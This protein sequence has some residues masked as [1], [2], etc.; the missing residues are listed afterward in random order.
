MGRT[1]TDFDKV[2]NMLN[3]KQIMVC[4]TCHRRIHR[5]VYDGLRLG[6]LYDPD[7]TTF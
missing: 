5:G 1:E 4:S 3:R 6:D 2:I 7:L